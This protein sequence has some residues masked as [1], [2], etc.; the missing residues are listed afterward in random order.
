VTQV[1]WW[2]P[3]D[4]TRVVVN[5]TN[6]STRQISSA[7]LQQRIPIYSTHIRANSTH[8]LENFGLTLKTAPFANVHCPSAYHCFWSSCRFWHP[9]VQTIQSLR[10]IRRECQ[11]NHLGQKIKWA[12]KRLKSSLKRSISDSASL[13]RQQ[14]SAENPSTPRLKERLLRQMGRKGEVWF[15]N[16]GCSCGILL[17]WQCTS[18]KW[19]LCQAV[20]LHYSSL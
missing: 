7:H 18:S 20:G 15:T 12:S 9:K 6:D 10:G 11:F 17:L 4:V 3:A 19:Y 8:L 5:A 16:C 14:C 1:T 2:R 13:I